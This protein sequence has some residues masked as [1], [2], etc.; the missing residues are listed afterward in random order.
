MTDLGFRVE[1]E[2]EKEMGNKETVSAE[3]EEKAQVSF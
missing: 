1:R 2:V 3:V